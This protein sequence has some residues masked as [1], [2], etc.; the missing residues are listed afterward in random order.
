MTKRSPSKSKERTRSFLQMNH[1]EARQFLLK[2]QSYVNFDL[3]QYFRFEDL[4]NDVARVL[5]SSK[6]SDMWKKRPRNYDGVNHSILQNKDGQYAWRPFSLIHPALYVSLVNNITESNN[7]DLIKKCF[8]DFRMDSRL[9]CL[10]IP[11]ESLTKRRTDKAAQITQWWETV[12]QRTLELSLQ[13]DF[14]A[15]TDI[16]DCYSSIYTHS[17]AWA[18]HTKATAKARRQD[19][20]L[21]GNVIDDTIQDMRQG[22]TNGIPQGSV[23][24]D[25]VAEMV[26]GYADKELLKRIQCEGVVDFQILRYRDDYRIFV[27]SSRD[28]GVILK[29]LTETMIDLGLR[30]NPSKTRMSEDIIGSS[31]KQDKLNWIFRK[32]GDDNIRKH[33]LII[34]DHSMQYQHSGSLVVALNDYYRRI[35]RI[36]KSKLKML[37]SPLPLISIVTEIAYRNPRTYPVAAAILSLFVDLVD[38]PSEKQRVINGIIKKCSQIPNTG[39]LEIWLQRFVQKCDPSLECDEPLCN[40]L[41]TKKDEALVWNNDWIRSRDLRK[42]IDT[43]KLVDHGTLGHM[44]AIIPPKE[45]ELFP[46]YDY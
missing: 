22:Q 26:L 27:N 5:K 6:L 17:I 30:L 32:Q 20:S 12:E 24:M 18:L 33:L 9:E 28:A 2:Q 1:L 16:V 45:I 41:R 13:Y 21:I 8:S 4:L 39:H 46:A 31:L 10:S 34:N 36:K 42:A 14:V 25:L 29:C 19:K 43:S 15:Y 23:L 7:W 40:L 35:S 11:V 44:P 38:S 3:P 37:E